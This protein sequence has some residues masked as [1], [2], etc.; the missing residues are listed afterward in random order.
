MKRFLA[1][2]LLLVSTL[3]AQAEPFKNT[4]LPAPIQAVM[5][6]KASNWFS[7]TITGNPSLYLVFYSVPNSKGKQQT[8]FKLDI[9]QR[10]GKAKPRRLHSITLPDDDYLKYSFTKE[11][12]R[13]TTIDASR[14]WL[15]SS[16]RQTP[17]ICLTFTS[18]NSVNANT[19]GGNMLFIF[20]GGFKNKPLIQ[21]FGNGS[22][23]YQGVTHTFDTTD[24][25]GIIQV[26]R[27]SW[28]NSLDESTK[29]TSTVLRWN[30]TAFVSPPLPD[31]SDSQ[32]VEDT[33]K[34]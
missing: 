2:S 31:T 15:R 32:Q 6:G 9:W 18:H 30:G 22:D 11:F 24:A 1:V 7:G 20:P 12:R 4:K 25:N 23:Q 5:P 3:A 29:D 17:V 26:T 14:L 33:T 13:Y 19:S 21:Q 28:I 34:P 16:T 10:S 8:T 27:N